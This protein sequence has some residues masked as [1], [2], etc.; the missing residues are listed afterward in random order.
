LEEGINHTKR[1]LENK[2]GHTIGENKPYYWGM[3]SKSLGILFPNAQFL[4]IPWQM[5][6]V[7]TS[8]NCH[9]GKPSW[10]LDE[11]WNTNWEL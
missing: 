8:F 1:D 7:F 9:K 3:I 11:V 2:D 6:D 5:G 4:S 10:H